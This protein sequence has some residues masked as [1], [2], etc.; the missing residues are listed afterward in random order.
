[1]H[2][3]NQIQINDVN[4][5]DLF[6]LETFPVWF[7]VLMSITRETLHGSGFTHTFTHPRPPSVPLM[8]NKQRLCTVFT[9]NILCLVSCRCTQNSCCSSPQHPI[10]RALN[11]ISLPSKNRKAQQHL[12]AP[13][14]PH[15]TT[16]I[17]QQQCPTL[18]KSGGGSNMKTQ[19]ASQGKNN[20]EKKTDDAAGRPH[21]QKH[22]CTH[23]H[24]HFPYR[25]VSYFS[26]C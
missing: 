6:L 22:W 14:T 8:Y 4:Y 12:K 13:P 10:V 7:S 5:L 2:W 1:M 9:Q 25:R 15:P 24:P 20:K 11:H 23:A 16:N 21:A 19:M 18:K 3:Q 26:Y 17:K